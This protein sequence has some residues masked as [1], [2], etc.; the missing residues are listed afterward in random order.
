[1]A[2]SVQEA[3]PPVSKSKTASTV[4]DAVVDRVKANEQKE[5]RIAVEKG[6]PDVYVDSETETSWYHWTGDIWVKPYR[7][8]NR[9]GTYVIGLKTDPRAEL[10]K[11]RHRGEVKAYTVRGSWGYYES[12]VIRLAAVK[13][14]PILHH[15]CLC[16]TV[17][18]P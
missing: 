15:L 13:P 10:G 8:N 18:L 5:L 17:Y 1:M 12:V 11:H 9:N 6:A 16:Q 3:A 7:F 2:P 4:S 14:F